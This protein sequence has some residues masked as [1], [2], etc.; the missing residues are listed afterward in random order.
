M[1]GVSWSPPQK[2]L[3]EVSAAVFHVRILAGIVSL[4]YSNVYSY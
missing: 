2:G 1:G 4:V 3:F